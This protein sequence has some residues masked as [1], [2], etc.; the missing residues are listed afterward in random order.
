MK[1]IPQLSAFA[2][3]FLLALS[4]AQAREAAPT[5][6]AEGKELVLHLSPASS[7]DAAADEAVFQHYGLDRAE[8]L[9]ISVVTNGQNLNATADDWAGMHRALD[10]LIELNVDQ[11]RLFKASIYGNMQDFAYRHD[12]G[13]YVAA[14]AAARQA[15]DLQQRAGVTATLYIP[16]RNLG[17]ELIHLGRVDEGAAAFRQARKFITDPSGSFA[18]DLWGEIIAVESSRGN[19]VVA[20]TESEAFL[21][22]AN[23]STPAMFRAD[24]LLAAAQVA[25]DDKRYDD[26]ITHIHE[27]AHLLKGVPDATRTAYQA[28]D[29][30]A[31]LGM[32]AMQTMPYDQAIALCGRLDKEFP[33][34][35]IS[36][37]SLGHLV[38]NQR[39]RLAGQFDLVLRDDSAQ[40]ESARA[41]TDLSGQVSALLSTA[42]DFG[43]L[44]E[45]TQEVAALEEAANILHTP[46][47][48][49][50]SAELRFRTL[51]ALGAGQLDR[52]DVLQARVAF[53]EV[54]N[55]IE[56]ITS[57]QMR[58]Q[59]ASLYADAQLGMAAA[60]ERAGNLQGARDLLHKS[61]DP[62][63]GALGRFIRSTV[64]LQLA[65][66]EESAESGLGAEKEPAEVIRLYLEAIAALHGESDR[67]GEQGAQGDPLATLHEQKDLNAGVNARLQFVQYL[68]TNGRSDA[69]HEAPKPGMRSESPAVMAR[70]QLALARVASTSIGLADCNWRIQFLEGILDENAGDRAAAI[71]SYSAAID[72]L[73]HIRAGLAGK[74]ERESFVDSASVQELYRR[75]IGLLTAGD[76]RE[77]AWEFLERNKARSFVETLHGRRFTAPVPIS[78]SPTVKRSAADLDVIEQQI[79]AARLSLSQGSQSTL[80][81]SGSLPDV[82]RANLV[83]LE[84]NFVLA[85]QQQ[86]LANSRATQPLALR[87]ISLATTQAQLP[88]G[89]ALIEYAILD[90]ELAA[91][92]VTH[93]S[94]KELHWPA[95]TAALPAQLDKLSKLLSAAH[96][97][98]DA[99]EAQLASASGILLGPVMSAL[100]PEIDSLIIVPTGSLSQV[101]FQALPLPGRPSNARGL[102]SDE[103][104][105]ESV[106]PSLRTLVIDRYAVSYL[107]SASTLQFLRFGAPVA[108][109]DLFLGAIGDLSVEGLPGL[110]GTLDETAGIQQLYPHA[111]R[112]TGAAFTHDVAVKALLEHQEV[113]FATHGLF[114]EQAP[115][116]SALIT[117]PAP[118]KPSRL[119]LYEL[120]DM[121][122]KARLVILSACETDR[123]QVTGGDEIAGLTRTFLQAGAENV[124]SSLWKVS[125][126]S[127]ALLMESLHAHLRA[128]ESTPVALRHAELQVR[129]KFPQPYFWAGFVDTG[130][131]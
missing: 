118:G 14:L 94:A 84:N 67:N 53:T 128:R 111:I 68:A 123:G 18:G 16:W 101:P 122:V 24:A 57:A 130:V 104:S 77:R 110:P 131:R 73:D 93:N 36:V 22:A 51:N 66:L 12:E 97:S 6:L 1:M 48:S 87:P 27:A 69:D 41:V 112:V 95:D 23:D 124:V 44:R 52:G 33:G 105:P 47:A 81:E 50:I 78:A 8:K 113:H 76:D 64:L 42:I 89:A 40:L 108:S 25:I 121:N 72:A 115:L 98:E 96:G 11:Q 129:R 99:V 9:L 90:H 114:E 59:L 2:G 5:D 31:T 10:G 80:R 116:F 26:A 3:C 13:D 102:V 17:E 34:L 43:Y 126:E 71:R 32:G 38:A 79:V 127:T 100:P 117:A 30:L 91:F 119:S 107:P 125:D 85:R 58:M 54:L 120:T 103:P 61:L 60:M 19:S 29:L 35:P 45:S 88:A 55:G 21:K 28:M 82:I 63:P 39:R 86:T 109:P 49:G 70:E 92:V 65:R 20:H 62:P 56:A 7:P 4:T 106:D 74:E 83:S 46:A 75:Q 15:L 37:S